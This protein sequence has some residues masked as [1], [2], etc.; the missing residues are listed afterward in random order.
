[1]RLSLE[2]SVAVSSADS[3]FA[4]PWMYPYAPVFWDTSAGAYCGHRLVSAAPT[5]FLTFFH[6]LMD[7]LASPFTS[8]AQVNKE[9]S[10]RGRG[11]AI[12]VT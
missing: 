4:T 1:M 6:D 5:A 8:G 12:T 9:R 7:A 10:L 11:E 3:P 2:A